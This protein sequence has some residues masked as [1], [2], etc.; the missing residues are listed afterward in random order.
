[1]RRTSLWALAVWAPLAA[2][3]VGPL[4]AQQL[5]ARGPETVLAVSISSFDAIERDVRRI[6]KAGRFPELMLPFQMLGDQGPKLVDPTKPAGAV[7]QVDG[8][9]SRVF[10]F[11]PAKDVAQV[12]PLLRP[13]SEDPVPTEPG[14]EGVYEV[15]VEG[16]A[17]VA[18]QKGPWAIF[19][20]NRDTL[21]Q[22]PDD[23]V[24]LL[25]GLDE[26]YLFA[27]RA[28]VENVPEDRRDQILG[29]I[30]VAADQ[31]GSLVERASGL[32]VAQERLS[33]ERA[34]SGLLAS[35]EQTESLL[36]GLAVDPKSAALRFDLEVEAVEG[37]PAAAAYAVA[38][39]TTSDLA[40]FYVPEAALTA[41]SA[42]TMNETA[43]AQLQQRIDVL[44]SGAA[45]DLQNQELSDDEREQARQMLDDLFD[46]LRETAASRRFDGGF[47]VLGDDEGASVVGATFVDDVATLEAFFGRVVELAIVEE[48]RL[49]EHVAL[50][51]QTYEGVR[52]HTLSI[53]AELLP[54][55]ELPPMIVADSLNAAVGFDDRHAY[56]A[57]GPE[58]I[59]QLKQAIDRSKAVA[60]ETVP[61]LRA[62]IGLGAVVKMIGPLVVA[63]AA[64][65][66]EQ[67]IDVPDARAAAENVEALATLLEQSQGRDH[68]RL[69]SQP[70][71]RGARIRLSV[72]PGVLKAAGAAAMGAMNQSGLG[73]AGFPGEMP[74]GE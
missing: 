39:A 38:A 70:I 7:V 46:V 64:T 14:D 71:P 6:A 32:P 42:G 34:R 43:A 66:A 15:E 29:L 63:T 9:R 52:L 23:P 57:V 56:L 21:D 4:E 36:V 54:A 33:G 73:P 59:D 40:G 55:G 65:A 11:L 51:A 22:V 74:E 2:W 1:M 18:A 49:A 69:A 53:P 19:A 16:L 48:P 50:D 68:V 27:V 47:A 8:D 60:G 67:G 62:S 20:D 41:H 5:E 35:L 61:P 58:S 25:E 10:A 37:T 24:P 31:F 45:K 12:L 72:E 26:S 28:S 3:S 30:E 44:A 17:I 13:F